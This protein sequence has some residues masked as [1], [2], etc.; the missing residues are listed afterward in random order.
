VDSRHQVLQGAVGKI[1]T[2]INLLKSGKYHPK[3][4]RAPFAIHAP[5]VGVSGVYQIYDNQGGLFSAYVDMVSDG[6]YWILDAIWTTSPAAAL[7][8]TFARG[9]QKGK[10]LYGYSNNPTVFPVIPTGKFPANPAEEWMLQVDSAGWKTRYGDWQRGT[11]FPSNKVSIAA[12][13]KVPVITPLGP[14]DLYGHRSGWYLA[15]EMTWGIGFWT[16]AGPSGP[17]GGNGQP[18]TDRI[19]PVMDPS[20]GQHADFTSVKRYFLRASNAPAR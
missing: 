11:L 19:C 4:S 15:T 9:M 13:E 14:K 16:I 3:Q 18:G 12:T 5:V 7:Q 10:P 1:M 6:G 17:C 2:A 8:V 20:Y